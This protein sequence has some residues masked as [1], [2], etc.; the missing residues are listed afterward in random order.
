MKI[1][2]TLLILLSVVA[3][4]TSCG[5][6]ESTAAGAVG[7]NYQWYER[8]SDELAAYTQAASAYASDPTPAKCE[9]YR[10]ALLDYLDAA[11]DVEACVPTASFSQYQQAIDQARAE[12]NALQ[13]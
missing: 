8:I 1:L 5:K 9:A 10:Q 12:A 4:T 2:R 3:F 11:E 13:C 7:C 6:K